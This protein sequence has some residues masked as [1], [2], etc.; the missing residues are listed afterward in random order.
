MN[1]DTT[2]VTSEQVHELLR[3]V[4]YPG[5]D[6][7]IVSAGF[8]KDVITNDVEVVVH[9]APNTSKTHK[10]RQMESGIQRV[11]AEAE[12]PGVRVET[13]LPFADHDMALRKPI[14]PEDDSDHTIDRAMTGEGAINPLQAELAQDGVT[15]DPDLLR[16]ELSGSNA[17]AGIGFGDNEPQPLEG[18]S[19]GPGDGYNGAM[20]VLQWDIDPHDSAAESVETSVQIDDWEIRVWWQEHPT[21][22]LVYASLQA[23]RDDWADHIGSARQHPVGRSAAVNLVFDRRREAVVAIYGTVRDFRPF[24]EAFRRAHEDHSSGGETGSNEETSK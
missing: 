24:V 10:I 3:K 4:P 7:D 16:S 8:V 17:A 2:K 13:S 21:G 6:R 14:T 9:F 23:M 22:D 20:P 5:F 19:G 18:P 15:G 1:G 11:L 12:I